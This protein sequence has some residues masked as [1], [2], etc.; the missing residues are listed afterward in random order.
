MLAD[1]TSTV[2]TGPVLLALVLAIAAGLV[3]FA[4]PCV[5]PLVPG[6]LSYLASL[7][8][9]NTPGGNDH[10]AAR[11]RRCLAGT[12]LFVLG[13]TIVFTLETVAVLGLANSLRAS[14]SL[15]TR[16]G[17]VITVLVGLVML[18]YVRPLQRSASV[19]TRPTQR[20][21]GAVFLGGIFAFGWTACLG[22][23][24]TGVISLSVATDWN[25]NAWRGLLLVLA[26]CVGLGLP[27]LALA[28]GVSW[29]TKTTDFLRRHTRG[30]QIIGGVALICIGLAMVTGAWEI[31]MAKL[32]GWYSGLEAVL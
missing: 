8:G 29:A 23:T 25:G 21:V 2:V 32:Q 3:S 7:T 6:Y 16:I 5:L 31:W 11:R 17:G 9:P 10:D 28:F 26:Y 1:V 15:L 22:P 19:S 20:Y 4:S 13:F 12:A 24:L 14:A 30:I 27:F 18:G